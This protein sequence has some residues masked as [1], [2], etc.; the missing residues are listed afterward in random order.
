MSRRHPSPFAI[1]GG[2]RPADGR[3]Q[4]GQVA[5]RGVGTR[6]QWAEKRGRPRQRAATTGNPCGGCGG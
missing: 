4:R 2:Y 5:R 6:T 3:E 1:G